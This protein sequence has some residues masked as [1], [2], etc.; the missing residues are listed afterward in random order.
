V[1]V[2]QPPLLPERPLAAVSSMLDG[3]VRPAQ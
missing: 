1:P 3:P 2:A